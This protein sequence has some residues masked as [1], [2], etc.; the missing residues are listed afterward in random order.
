MTLF[1][2]GEGSS[3]QMG[4]CQIWQIEL[5]DARLNLGS[6]RA[7]GHVLVEAHRCLQTCCFPT[8]AFFLPSGVDR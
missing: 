5:E 8:V 6:R 3:R 2:G 7:T 1:L 4:G